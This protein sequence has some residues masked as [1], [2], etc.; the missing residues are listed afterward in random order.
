MSDIAI[1]ILNC[2]SNNIKFELNRINDS[3][4]KY[5]HIDI[6][7]GYFEIDNLSPDLPGEISISFNR[8]LG[9]L[10][11]VWILDLR[12][13]NQKMDIDLDCQLLIY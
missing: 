10:V 6:M 9:V 3:I 1:S 13:I 11:Q 4:I 8:Q 5:I 2:D 7:D 12:P